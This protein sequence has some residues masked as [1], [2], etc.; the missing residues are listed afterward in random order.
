[1]YRDFGQ[2]VT[3]TVVPKQAINQQD[4]TVSV[5]LHFVPKS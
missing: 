2:R 5:S 3:Y 4:K 1:M